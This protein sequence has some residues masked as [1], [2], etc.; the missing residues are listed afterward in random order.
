MIKTEISNKK[1]TSS[2]EKL[3]NKYK[4]LSKAYAKKVFDYEKL[5]IELKDVEQ[6]LNIKLFLSI[7]AYCRAWEKYEETK[8]YKPVPIVYYL[9]FAMV[10]RVRD[11][12][13][14][15]TREGQHK[16]SIEEISFD[17]GKNQSFIELTNKKLEINGVDILKGLKEEEKMVFM[18]H[19][20]GHNKKII[21]KLYKG[22]RQID[23]IIETHQ[24]SLKSIKH[25]LIT[26]QTLHYSYDLND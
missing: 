22:E 21:Q 13:R 23:E 4:Y 18:M 7:E 25:E 26:D 3:F 1:E 9:R 5:G 8:K 11:F 17:V 10:N 16:T 14:Q 15:I 2:L 12:A 6:E 19:V 20:K 24:N